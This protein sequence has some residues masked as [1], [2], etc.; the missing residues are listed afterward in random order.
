MIL[1]IFDCLRG[2]HS[3]ILESHQK[4]Q[5]SEIKMAI[6]HAFQGWLPKT[7]HTDEIVCP[8]YDVI[9]TDEAAELAEGKPNSYLHVIR[10]EIDLPNGTRFDDDAVY[11]TGATHLRELLG[12]GLMEQDT[13]PSVYLYRMSTGDHSQTGLF[14]CAS[15]QDYDADVILKHELT[16]PDKEDD[17]TRHILTQR[18]HAEPVMLTYKDDAGITG[19]MD[20]ITGMN[21]PLLSHTSEDGVL[22][23]IWRA[24][25]SAEF[26]ERFAGIPNLYVADGHHRCKSASRVA[27]ELRK[28]DGSHPG[29]AEYDYFPVVL[30]PMTQ[31]R[32]LPYNR[33][34]LE[35]SEEQI[36]QLFDRFDVNDA[37]HGEQPGDGH[38]SLFLKDRW[39]R[40]ALPEPIE[41][42]AVS[43]LDVARLQSFVL[44]P[45][46]GIQNPRTDSRIAF[47]GGSRGTA[48]LEKRVR[49]GKA[50][51]AI[52]MAPTKIEE[53]VEV[54]DEHQL[55]PPKS[56]W[57]EP[58]IRSGF[59]IH[60]F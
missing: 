51:L 27:E 33:V 7:E 40:M 55:M 58:K 52:S 32:I 29:E 34:I 6:I 8:P 48:E 59:V 46:F 49:S 54:S 35:A 42:D 45:I 14:A 19:L 22:H 41:S 17:R 28:S 5:N 21:L 13:T 15:V 50:V 25:K 53:L 3:D 23:E 44:E 57:F 18:A 1:F 16:R 39:Y 36:Q 2:A 56:T 43:A 30:F 60:T 11:E 47:V 20:E 37:E 10:P 12:S 26:V 9:S 38:V 24:P 4:Y 31:M